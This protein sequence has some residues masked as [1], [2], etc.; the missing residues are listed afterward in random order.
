MKQL[1]TDPGTL[2]LIPNLAFEIVRNFP[3]VVFS[4]KG[5]Q[6]TQEA[7]HNHTGEKPQS[8]W[9]ETTITQEEN[10]NHTREKPQSQRRETTITQERN[11]DHTGEKPQSHRG[12]TTI[13]EERRVFIASPL[14]P[15]AEFVLLIPYPH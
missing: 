3:V 11:H 2:K 4:N 15:L 5:K 12:E 13:T 6:I 14:P 10:H 9:R 7:N 1:E 8:H